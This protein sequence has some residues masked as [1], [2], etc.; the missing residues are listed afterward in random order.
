MRIKAV[1]V[2]SA[3][4]GAAVAALAVTGVAWGAGQAGGP[5]GTPLTADGPPKETCRGPANGWQGGMQW[6]ADPEECEE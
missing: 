2:R 6:P 3:L 4:A 1:V 5:A